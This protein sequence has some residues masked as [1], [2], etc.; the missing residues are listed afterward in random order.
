V[1]SVRGGA[2]LGDALYV[3]A[4]A[5]HMVGRGMCDVEVCTEWPDV[6]RPLGDKVKLSPFRRRP[7][8]HL[9]HYSLRRGITGTSQ[10]EDCCIQARVAGPVDLRID[11]TP[12]NAAL[13]SRLRS[14]GRPVVL[15]QMPRTPFDRTDGFGAEFL[16]DVAMIQRAIDKLRDKAFLVQI[17]KGR[18][19][20]FDGKRL[21]AFAGYGGIDLDLANTTSVA[22][23]IDAAF[24]AD[25]F[26]GQCSF[27]V[28]LAESFAKPALFVWSRRGLNSPHQVIR[29]MAPAKVLH[30]KDKCRAVIDDCSDSELAGNIDALCRSLRSPVAA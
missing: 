11:W 29:Q 22:D 13:V 4:I 16:P 27:M 12:V 26:L 30:R 17:G 6:F 28:P 10:F 3:Q 24:A 25:A 14:C 8:T 20:R 2:G 19:E 18:P 9:A 7:I 1:T 15:V 5:R 21:V 23:V